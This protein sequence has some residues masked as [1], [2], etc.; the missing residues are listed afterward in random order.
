MILQYF[1][2]IATLVLS[3]HIGI[4][5]SH[6][7]FITLLLFHHYYNHLPDLTFC[8]FDFFLLN[9]NLIIIFKPFWNDIQN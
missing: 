7:N 4:I 9:Y 5:S 1:N 2:V 3:N 8:H 6:C